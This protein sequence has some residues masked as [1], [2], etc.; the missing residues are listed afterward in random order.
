MHVFRS[1]C[2]YSLL[3]RSLHV[4]K[5]SYGHHSSR[6]SLCVQ[7]TQLFSTTPQYYHDLDF[8]K[9]KTST[10]CRRNGTGIHLSKHKIIQLPVRFFNDFKIDDND[11]KKPVKFSTPRDRIHGGKYSDDNILMPS[12]P[13]YVFP[14]LFGIYENIMAGS[15][16]N[17]VDSELTVLDFMT[18][19]KKAVFVIANLLSSGKVDE[20]ES[21]TTPKAFQEIK[22]NFP[23]IPETHLKALEQEETMILIPLRHIHRVRLNH[24]AMPNEA[25]SEEAALEIVVLFEGYMRESVDEEP[26]VFVS[27]KGRSRFCCT[28]RFERDYRKD[29]DNSTWEGSSAWKVSGIS[30][31]IRTVDDVKEEVKDY[32]I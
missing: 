16:I 22:K 10:I 12:F 24:K 27:L 11:E 28:A 9:K 4:L 29:L 14:N 13:A 1:H 5:D 6:T 19:A 31:L 8:G 25:E 2:K 7:V 18:A 20:I 26:K 23:K 30:Y 17:K 3:N 21:L 32:A 15:R